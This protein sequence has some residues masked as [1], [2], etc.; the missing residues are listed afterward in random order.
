M[1]HQLH[2]NAKLNLGLRIVGKRPDGFHDLQTVFLPLHELTDTMDIE[3]LEGHSRIEITDR[4]PFP[5]GNLMSHTVGTAYHLLT[6]YQPQA[7]RITLT[8]RIPVGA[9]LGGGSADG[10]A[11]L[12]FAAQRCQHPLDI[13]LTDLALRIGSD[14][15]FFLHNAPC[16]AQGRG[17]ILSPIQWPHPELWVALVTPPIHVSTPWAFANISPSTPA[18]APLP[19]LIAQPL[20]RWQGTVTNDFQPLI[21]RT[22]PRVAGIVRTLYAMGASYAALSGSGPSCYGLFTQRP[23]FPNGSFQGDYTHIQ[24]IAF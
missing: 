5:M 20:D 3:L 12:Q 4:S 7:M 9:G 2:P 18:P 8:K 13:P 24:R 17:E 1:K 14:C 15:P 6:P 10:T 23:E 22:Y 19:D 21:E 11:F 16:Y